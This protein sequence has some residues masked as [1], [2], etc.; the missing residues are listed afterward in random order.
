MSCDSVYRLPSGTRVE[1]HL[2][3]AH[4][5][6]SRVSWPV[7]PLGSLDYSLVDVPALSARLQLHRIG[8]LSTERR[9]RLDRCTEA[10]QQHVS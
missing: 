8:Q 1:L 4:I 2:S 3:L 7:I 5:E 9:R 6:P 10:N